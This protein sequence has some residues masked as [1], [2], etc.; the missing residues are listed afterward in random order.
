MLLPLHERDVLALHVLEYCIAGHLV[1]GHD[2]VVGLRF[3]TDDGA[4]EDIRRVGSEE[5][6]DHVGGI[7]GIRES[8]ECRRDG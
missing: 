5:E 3:G 8:T 4:V 2:S 6:R 1:V 7:R